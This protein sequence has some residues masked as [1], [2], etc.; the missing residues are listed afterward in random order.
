MPERR[1]TRD[2]KENV[3]MPERLALE[4]VATALYSDAAS[5]QWPLVSPRAL[6]ASFVR[7]NGLCFFPVFLVFLIFLVFPAL[8][9]DRERNALELFKPLSD[10]P[11]R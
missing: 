7:C 8:R 10:G 6:S 3:G 1:K 5:P 11:T 2:P 4:G 9:R